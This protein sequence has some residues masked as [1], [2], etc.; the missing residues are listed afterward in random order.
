M[1]RKKKNIEKFD[2]EI[3][4]DS[5]DAKAYSKGEQRNHCTNNDRS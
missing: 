1:F 5:L 2:V 3:L 4:G